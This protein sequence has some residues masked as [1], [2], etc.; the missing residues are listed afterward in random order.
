MSEVKTN[1]LTGTGTAGSI[2][3]TGEGNS[4]TTNLQ[5]GLAKAWVAKATDSSQSV[6]GDTFNTSGF[7][8]IGTGSSDHTITSV[9]SADDYCVMST[10]HTSYPYHGR[11]Q[12]TSVYRLRTVNSSG[13][14]A[15]GVKHGSVHGDL[16]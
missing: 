3:V 10:A 13:S 5:Q 4:T 15:D 11:A 9:M 8:D 6:A 12:S 7:T 2:A 14:S 16:A 1:K